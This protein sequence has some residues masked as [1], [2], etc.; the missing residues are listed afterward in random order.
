ME[1]EPG[2]RELRAARFSDRFVAYLIDV[3]P[4]A[5]GLVGT[6]YAVLI[7]LAKP[8]TPETIALIASAWITAL[9]G[10]QLIGNLTGATLGKRLIGLRLIRR[11][12]APPGFGRALIRAAVW[13]LG[14]PVA[15]FGFLVALLNKENRALHDFASGTVVVEAYRKSHAEGAALFLAAAIGAAGLFGWQI[16]SGWARPTPNDLQAVAKARKGLDV[17][18]L[19]QEAYKEKHGVYASSIEQLAEVSGDPAEF[20]AAMAALFLPEP[21]AMEAGNRGWRIR[22]V[23]RDRHKTK[24]VRDGP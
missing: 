21:F 6:V 15:S 14:T 8:P 12:G 20:R 22:A 24:I 23:A 4:F 2:A 10:Y 16:Y 3:V 9:F 18:A 5:A 11:D 1:N 13:M 7:P 19:V 17:I